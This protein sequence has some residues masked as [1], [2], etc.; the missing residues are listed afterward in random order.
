MPQKALCRKSCY[1]IF[2][3]YRTGGEVCVFEIARMYSFTSALKIMR[4]NLIFTKVTNEN[5]EGIS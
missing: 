2:I 5:T 4:K 3:K 1:D